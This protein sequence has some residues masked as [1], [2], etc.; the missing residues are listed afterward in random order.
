MYIIIYKY[1]YIINYDI[2]L[3]SFKK[4]KIVH[5]IDINNKNICNN[6]IIDDFI[7]DDLS[8]KI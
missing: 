1:I 3:W 2:K 8:K 6:R 4:S 5:F 7:D